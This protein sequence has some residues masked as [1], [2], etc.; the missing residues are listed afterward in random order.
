MVR[1]RDHYLNVFVLHQGLKG[2]SAE[3]ALK[4]LLPSFAVAHTKKGKIKLPKV[5]EWCRE[6]TRSSREYTRNILR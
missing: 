4:E 6:Y 5:G 1:T 3:D 2:A